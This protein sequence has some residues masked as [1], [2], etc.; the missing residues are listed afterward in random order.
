MY[1]IRLT[2]GALASIRF[3]PS[4]LLEA[5][6]LMRH[7]WSPAWTMTRTP[8][9]SRVVARDVPGLRLLPALYGACGSYVPDFLTPV[10]GEG[11]LDAELHAVATTAPERIAAELRAV[12]GDPDRDGRAA[13]LDGLL[14][15]LERGEQDCARLAADELA[16]FWRLALAPEWETVR[17]RAEVDIERHAILAAREGLG[18]A[19]TALHPTVDF[20]EDVLS[21]VHVSETSLYADREVVLIPSVVLTDG[22]G[23]GEDTLGERATTVIYPMRR[24]DPDLRRPGR[25]ALAEVLGATRVRLLAAVARPR[26]TTQLA[27]NHRLAPATVSYHLGRLHRCGLVTRHRE[28]ASVYYQHTAEAGRLLRTGG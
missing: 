1:R 22:C 11:D 8:W 2:A 16:L 28:G 26:T 24:I 5:S 19:L 7:K 17:A 9:T 18:R 10:P 21:V 4:P 23:V 3:A 27:R 15:L 14:R 12:A 20:H 25:S 13:G 6:V